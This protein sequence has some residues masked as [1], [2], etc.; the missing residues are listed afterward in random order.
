VHSYIIDSFIKVIHGGIMK[1]LDKGIIYIPINKNTTKEEMDKL[2]MGHQNKTVVF[3]RS[4]DG[5]M[6]KILLNFLVPR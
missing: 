4:G 5:N 2:R 6:Q 1:Y 3:L